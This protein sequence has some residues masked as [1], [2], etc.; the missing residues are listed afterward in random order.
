M[1]EENR[2]SNA[3]VMQE[4]FFELI[5]IS[6]G[7]KDSFERLPSNREWQAL[8]GLACKQS[9]ESVLLEGVKR[10]KSTDH[11]ANINQNL[12]LEWI[13]VGLQTESLNKVQNERAK[14]LS[15][16]FSK[17]GFRSCVLKGQGTALYYDKPE[18]RQCGD[19]DIWITDGSGFMVQGSVDDVR[20]RVLAFVKEKG[21]QVGHVD[22]KHSDIDFFEDVPVEVHFMPSWMYCPSTNKKLLRFFASKADRQFANV[23]EKLEFAHTTI[24]FDLVYSMVHIYRHIF[25]E[26]IGLRQL[27]DY[28]YILQRSTEEQR[29]DA[30]EVLTNLKMKSF[31]CGIMCILYECFG[32]KKEYMLCTANERHGRFLLSEIMTAGSFGH[33][34]DRTKQVSKDK[35]FERGLVQLG[36]NLRF[37]SYYPSEVLWSPFW[38]LWHWCWRKKKGYL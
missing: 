21:F 32:M 15:D 36:R 29:Q 22:I 10:L 37:V 12:L 31:V 26:G 19:I 27:V 20:D 30:F 7:N 33:F 14:Q 17:N 23:D 24:D 13:G 38:K 9:L 25:S 18:S 34:D 11:S 5:Q 6:L 16:F 3:K 2:L 1:G 35:K 8:F 28:Y 4:L